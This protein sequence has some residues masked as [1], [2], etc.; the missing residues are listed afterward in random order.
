VVNSRY[1]SNNNKKN[2][3][4]DS[5]KTK[6]NKTRYSLGA[7]FDKHIKCE[8]QDHDVD[9]TMKTMVKEPYVH[10]VPALTGGVGYDEVYNFYKTHFVGKMPDDTKIERISR[11]VG[12]D[13]VVDEIIIKFTHSR[14]IEYMIPGIPPTGKYVELPHVVVMKFVGN[15]IAHEH[16][17]WDQASVLAQIGL[18]DTNTLPVRGIEQSKKLQELAAAELRL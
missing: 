5:N 12:K 3:K 14:E 18:L 2:N 11:T 7:I 17:Y 9:A 16:I 6:R 8:F 13:Q 1:I 4:K 10:H 15:K